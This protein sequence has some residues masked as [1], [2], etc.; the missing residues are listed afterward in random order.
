MR[1]KVPSQFT[2]SMW[3]NFQVEF[4]F[5]LFT[6]SLENLASIISFPLVKS[7]GKLS[8]FI[9]PI[10]A[11]FVTPWGG[12]AHIKCSR[13]FYFKSFFKPPFCLVCLVVLELAAPNLTDHQSN[14]CFLVIIF[15]TSKQLSVIT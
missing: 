11:R 13:D 14:S 2:H 15:Q 6:F 1:C 12:G 9:I 7:V 4:F 10:A 8:L 3:S 5:P